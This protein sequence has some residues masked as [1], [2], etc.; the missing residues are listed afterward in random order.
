[1]KQITFHLPEFTSKALWRKTLTGTIDGE[2][3]TVEVEVA[4]DDV[5]VVPIRVIWGLA[6][7][8]DDEERADVRP[9]TPRANAHGYIEVD[10]LARCL[11]DRR[12]DRGPAP[13][14]TFEAR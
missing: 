1:M 14:C 3:G 5:I 4:P 9:L 11:R 12:V 6:A 8:L 13:D 7:V 10:M 2:D